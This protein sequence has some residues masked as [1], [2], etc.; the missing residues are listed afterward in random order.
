MRDKSEGYIK[1]SNFS[2]EECLS[3]IVTDLVSDC[4]TV[5]IAVH[6]NNDSHELESD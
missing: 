1:L 2:N 4:L 5:D 6:K 3:I